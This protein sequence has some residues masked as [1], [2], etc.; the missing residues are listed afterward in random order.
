[1]FL[2][3]GTFKAPDLWFFNPPGAKYCGTLYMLGG[4]IFLHCSFN[5][6]AAA[7]APLATNGYSCAGWR[8]Q[9]SGTIGTAEMY[10]YST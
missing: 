5:P 2:G 3:F 6:A 4:F 7:A 9:A 10:G 8:V 1:M